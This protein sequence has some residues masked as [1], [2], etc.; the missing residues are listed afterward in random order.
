MRKLL[1]ALSA[2]VCFS[3]A[4]ANANPCSDHKMAFE[5]KFLS[6][7]EAGVTLEQL[8]TMDATEIRKRIQSSPNITKNLSAPIFQTPLGQDFANWEIDIVANEEMAK[9][10]VIKSIDIYP[11]N[12]S[13]LNTTT[14]QA[15]IEFDNN[16]LIQYT[17][18]QVWVKV[19]NQSAPDGMTFGLMLDAVMSKNDQRSYLFVKNTVNKLVTNY[20]AELA[21]CFLRR[22]VFTI[23]GEITDFDNQ[24]RENVVDINCVNRIT[25]AQV[26][27][28]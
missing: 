6:I 3:A 7:G 2:F 18:L 19:L 8:A 23:Y 26:L 17:T 20:T 5:N 9:K 27:R 22:P 12:S 25:D 13:S 24:K 1:L 16:S 21:K 15:I 28:Q 11:I 10:T 14:C 4:T